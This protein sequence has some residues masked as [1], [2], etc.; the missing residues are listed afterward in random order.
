MGS[1]AYFA[2]DLIARKR[3]G[4][5]LTGEQIEWLVQ[6]ITDNSVSDSQIAAMTMAVCIRGMEHAEM[7]DLTQ[8]MLD[9][10]RDRKSVV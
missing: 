8:A 7:R 2:Q 10:G 9:S 4:K 6:G 1:T 5:A 3:A